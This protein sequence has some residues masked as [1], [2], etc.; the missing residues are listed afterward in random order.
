MENN[1]LN[2]NNGSGLKGNMGVFALAMTA[3][4]F[5]AP[6]GGCSGALPAFLSLG[7]SGTTLIFLI[8]SIILIL[9]SV[10]FTK[11]G[12]VM[13]RPGG[14]YA[15][16]TD[17]L[18]KRMGFVTAGMASVG[19]VLVALWAP[20]L[21]AIM[22]NNFIG[23]VFGM[24]PLPW[25]VWAILITVLVMVFSYHRIDLSAKVMVIVMA[26]EAIAVIIFD[27][28]CFL[29]GMPING[30]AAMPTGIV[31]N[32]QFGA[33]VLMV[34]GA[35]FGFEAV[36]I[37][38]EETKDPEKTMPRAVFTTVI[39]LGVFWCITSWAYIAYWGNDNIEMMANE[40]MGT[41][42]NDTLMAITSK[43]VMDV[44]SV[45]AM[46]SVFASQLAITNTANRYWYSLGV[47][48][49]LP[50]VYGQ[51][52]P[53]HNSPYAAALTIGII[54]CIL[55]IVFYIAQPDAPDLIYPMFSGT[56]TFFVTVNLFLAAL[57]IPVYF[58]K[59]KIA[60]VTVWQSL[61]CPII[62]AIAIAI[63]MVLAV[64]HFE[65]LLGSSGW[66][67]YAFVAFVL[68]V[69]FGSFFYSGYIKKNKPDVYEKLG[70]NNPE[71][72]GDE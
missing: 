17:G 38:R 5:V 54:H 55:M 36:V 6:L 32:G 12:S 72:A 48:G 51:A 70:R 44:V 40:H 13:A 46:I 52:H 67:T 66:A 37:F 23:N 27:I 59:N 11:M 21:F 45:F 10:G 33:A 7:G 50:K 41:I 64:I 42:F 8:V 24:Q 71:I 63:I 18:G 22:V 30:S 62:S 14:F 35:F 58:A 34:L 3:L 15:Y 60:G 57:A 69:F 68:I 1:N 31:E 53:K 20:P 26:L 61:I 49:V 47:D 2:G 39:L 25:V 9:F 56:G 19:Y 4:A 65:A 28:F 29:K 16:V 43:I